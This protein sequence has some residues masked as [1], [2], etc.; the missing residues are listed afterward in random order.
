MT[1]SL[2]TA[3]ALALP[4]AATGGVRPAYGGTIRM[5]VPAPAGAGDAA[6]GPGDALLLAATRGR[7][8]ELDQTGALRPGVL[9]EV[10]VPE[11]GGR[12]FRLRLRPGLRAPSGAPLRASD[13]AAHLTALLSPAHPSPDAWIALP[14]V[15][16]DGV[17]ERR[18]TALAGA[19]VLSDT[20]LLVTLSFPLPELPWLLATLPAGLP[21]AGPFVAP[22]AATPGAPTLLRANEV[23]HRGRPFADAL[24]IRAADA[25]TSPRLVERGEAHLA[26]RP[27]PAGGLAGRA[28]PSLAVTV[29][30]VNAARLG[31]G[32]EAV[33]RALA[34][35]DRVDLARGFVR[36]PAEPLATI[37]PPAL[38]PAAP[39]APTR[40]PPVSGAAPPRLSLLAAATAPDQRALAERIQVRL[41][42]LGIR[43]AL[44]LVDQAGYSAAM[45]AGDYDVALVHVPVL[46][47]RPALAAG[48]VAFAARGPA[49]ARQAMAA[50]AGLP[51]AGALAAA[52]A[53]S[54]KL[55]IVPLVAA[56]SRASLAPA[57]QGLLFAP[58]G[59]FDPGDLWLL[60]GGAP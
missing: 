47:M 54:R 36:G 31:P 51:A 57:L 9:A 43:A 38:L 23:H 39:P 34:A 26:I 33:R 28:L 8:L 44:H 24:E 18:A 11:A 32:A 41:F 48:Q 25:R 13:L 17:L 52:D 45:R 27:E 46:G 56:G 49:A 22:L 12:A 2:A 21:G 29:A 7:L 37:V 5:T 19:Q 55:W 50:L 1:R 35:M 30:V 16:A 58:D 3:I 40:D 15:G 42:D 6:R 59:S 60:G 14:I 10:P 20:E 53:L 4:V